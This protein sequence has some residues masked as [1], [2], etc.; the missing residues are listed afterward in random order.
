MYV[1][2]SRFAEPAEA[3]AAS[4]SGPG[5]LGQSE[6]VLPGAA[7]RSYLLPSLEERRKA[8]AAKLAE[9]E[10]QSR[11]AVAAKLREVY[12]AE[13]ARLFADRQRELDA[14]SKDL[15]R[16]LQER[17]SE[18]FLRYAERNGRALSEIAV[19][20]GYPDPG[21]DPPPQQGAL[22]RAMARR[23][24][25]ARKERESAR[26]A[27]R[28]EV[29][30]IAASLGQEY[31]EQAG[32]L[33]VEL[34]SRR[35]EADRRADEEAARVARGYG[36]SLRSLLAGAEQVIA[37]SVPERRV[38]LPPVS[39]PPPPPRVPPRPRNDAALSARLVLWA[40]WNGY[41]LTGDPAKGRD[42]TEE[43]ARWLEANPA[44]R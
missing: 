19:A 13:L 10:E 29:A 27:F 4:P 33:A 41:K 24:D 12:R 16:R 9:L 11:R 20:Y 5:G 26:E 31:A 39:A 40:A 2:L 22:A 15:D 25:A 6:K 17:I 7:G 35:A 34:E 43:F 30:E 44:L 42:A 3:A 28:R 38:A 37:P 8:A 1:D 36:S 21:G 23:L 32:R 14:L 18:A